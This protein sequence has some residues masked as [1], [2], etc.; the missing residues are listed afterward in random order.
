MKTQ[1]KELI[2]EIVEQNQ[3]LLQNL[4]TQRHYEC[5]ARQLISEITGQKIPK[6]TEIRLPFYTDYGHN[7]KIGERVFINSNVMMVDL[8]GITIEDDVLIGPGAYLLSVNHGLKPKQRKE[9]E[10]KPVLIKKNAWIGARATICPGVIVGENAVVAAG[11]VVTKDVPKNTVIAGVPA[12]M[13]KKNRRIKKR[14]NCRA[15]FKQSFYCSIFLRLNT[16]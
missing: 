14:D 9:L 10:L 2:Q 8:G 6:S 11:A 16:R 3:R 12:K 15:F 13:I 7:I 1:D 4:N 5:E